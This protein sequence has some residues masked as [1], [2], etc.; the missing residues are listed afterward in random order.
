MRAWL[1]IAVLAACSAPAPSGGQDAPAGDRDAPPQ[2][3]DGSGSGSAAAF[4]LTSTDLVEG[5]AFDPANT[6]DGT[7]GSPTLAWTGG[8]AAQ[9]YAV[10]L[11]D[12]SIGLDHWFIYDIAAPGSPLPAGVDNSA[13]PT[14]VPGAH[15]TKSYDN[16][17]D[18]YLGPC[19]PAKHTYT[20]TVF[21]LDVATLPG[22]PDR[23][24]AKAVIQAHARDMATL[25]G[26]YE[27]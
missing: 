21:A 9:S 13:S 26:T 22:T 4:A 18:G 3:G 1:P 14:D 8:P 24:H 20:F 2:P 7:A 15:Q 23:T 5:G 6:C 25:T 19:P 11:T 17:T 16:T 12:T 10:I 27:H